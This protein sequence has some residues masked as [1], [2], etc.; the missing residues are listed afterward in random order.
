[1]VV[2]SLLPWMMMVGLSSVVMWTFMGGLLG[3]YVLVGIVINVGTVFLGLFWRE[4]NPE[5]LTNRM[6]NA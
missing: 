3:E 2:L 5:E 1:M 4:T 6:H